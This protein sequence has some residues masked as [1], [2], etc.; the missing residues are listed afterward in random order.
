MPNFHIH[1]GFL[2]AGNQLCILVHSLRDL[3]ITEVHSGGLVAHIG[4]NKTLALLEG[5]FYWPWIKRNVS[6]FVERCIIFQ[7]AKGTHHNIGLYTPLP[8]TI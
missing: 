5:R 2:F 4:R 1:R 6:K 7:T 8:A 3:L